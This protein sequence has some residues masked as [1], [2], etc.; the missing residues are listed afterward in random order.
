ML[1]LG[2]FVIDKN[3]DTCPDEA[4][5]TNDDEGPFPTETLGQQ[6]DS[7]RRSQCAHG[8]TR[9]EK[10]RGK[11]TVFFREILGRYLDSSREV[12][13]FTKTE[14]QTADKEQPHTH[15]RY[16]TDYCTC[17]IQQ[18]SLIGYTYDL[19]GYPAAARMHYRTDR[20]Y[21]NGN[22]VT[23]FRAHP[24]DELTSEKTENRISD[25]EHT[26]NRS[27]IGIGPMELRLNKLFERQREDLTVHIVDSGGE[28][29]HRTHDPTPVGHDRF[30]NVV[31]ICLMLNV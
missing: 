5:C 3:P 4:Q 22:Q 15:H 25:R 27:V 9:I 7:G 18:F 1:A 23:F 31:H 8:C 12:T 13:R 30:F 28:E 2:R 21:N 6:R 16:R 10:R 11:R 17:R 14:N 29:K 24:V 20:P 19:L 26:G